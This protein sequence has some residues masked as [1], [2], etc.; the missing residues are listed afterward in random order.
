ML[1]QFE[2]K[3]VGWTHFAAV[4]VDLLLIRWTHIEKVHGELSLMEG[5][6]W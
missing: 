4:C 5:T 3:I 1:Q 2:A 6:S